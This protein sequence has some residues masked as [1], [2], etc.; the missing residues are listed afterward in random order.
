MMN[1]K[2]KGERIYLAA[3]EREHCKI[4]NQDWEYDFKNITESLDIYSFDSLE[5]TIE[6]SDEWFEDIKKRQGNGL[7]TLGVFLSDGNVI[8]YVRLQGIDW[9]NKACAVGMTIA[10]IENRNKGYGKEALSLILD[11][12]FM[13][14]GLERVGASTSENNTSAR[15]SLLSAGFILEGQ[16][17]KAVYCA[18]KKY[19]KC[20][21]SILAEEYIKN[22]Y[23]EGE[24]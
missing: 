4:I 21:Y 9:R 11:Y 7:V 24:I 17:R 19:D 15:K 12:A 3:L 6:K 22:N 20:Y 2:L 13:H 8:G 18:G 16:H 10:K 1:I 23:N 14:L 5:T